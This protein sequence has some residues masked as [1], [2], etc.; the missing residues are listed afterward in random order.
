MSDYIGLCWRYLSFC[1]GNEFCKGF[2]LLKRDYISPCQR[3]K[4][5]H[6]GAVIMDSR[7]VMPIILAAALL[8]PPIA[9]TITKAAA[10][11]GV[12]L[13]K[14]NTPKDRVSNRNM[15]PNAMANA[16]EMVTR[17]ML[18]HNEKSLILNRDL[19]SKD[20]PTQINAKGRA[21]ADK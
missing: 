16:G 14:N 13:I 3:K 9:C 2:S 6:I 7:V 10:A 8:L 18:V 1:F 20:A 17:A 11:I 15:R 4:V 19:K 21:V 5:I 12:V